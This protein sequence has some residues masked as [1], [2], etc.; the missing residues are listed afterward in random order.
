V[1]GTQTILPVMPYGGR[2]VSGAIVACHL[3]CVY[4]DW[5]GN[6]KL[7]SFQTAR[8]GG[9]WTPRSSIWLFSCLVMGLPAGVRAGEKSYLLHFGTAWS[10]SRE[11]R[12]VNEISSTAGGH[13]GAII[14]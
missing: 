10:L 11:K 14:L 9:H 7:K 3:S 4:A 2:G 8:V 6:M 12:R 5:M 1:F 13:Q